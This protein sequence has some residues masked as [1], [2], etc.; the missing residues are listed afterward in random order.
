M[1]TTQEEPSKDEE[2]SEALKLFEQ[3]RLSSGRAAELCRMTRFDFLLLAGRSGIPVVDL[4]GEELDRE[5]L[6]A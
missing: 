4:D 2:L 6:D 3:G 1:K 5:F